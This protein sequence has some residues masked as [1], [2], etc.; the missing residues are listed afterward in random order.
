M[1]A[2]LLALVLAGCAAAPAS[3][4]RERPTPKPTI[5]S[6]NPCSDAILAEVA[7]P[8]QIVAISHYSHDPRSTSMDLAAA[9]QFRATSG[10]EEELVALAPDLVVGSSFMAPATLVALGKLGLRV[11]TFGS[12]ATAAESIAQVRKLAALAGQPARGEDLVRRIEA[13]LIS[14]PGPPVDTALWQAGGIVPGRGTLVADLMH[15]AGLASYA[16]ARGLGQGDYL[17]LERI[18]ADPPTLLLVAGEERAQRHPLLARIPDLRVARFEP[19]LFYCGGPSIPKAMDRLRAILPGTGRG[20]TRRV[21]GGQ[22]PHGSTSRRPFKPTVPLH[23][24]LRA[25]SP[26]PVGGGS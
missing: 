7:D 21:V 14:P 24:A 18:A 8:A 2:A 3:A 6:L 17:P 11:E 23:P 22:V 10:A 12:P 1:R 4:P 9:R 5:V 19:R 25:R 13:S 15:H 20:T 16:E 26:S